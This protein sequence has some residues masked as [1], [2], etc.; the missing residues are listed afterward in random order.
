MGGGRRPK[1]PAEEALHRGSLGRLP[2]RSFIAAFCN[3]P[4]KTYETSRTTLQKKCAAKQ[5]KQN[6]KAV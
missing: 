3:K 6:D 2:L 1:R 4:N 5:M